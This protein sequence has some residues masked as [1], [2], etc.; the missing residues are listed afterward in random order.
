MMIFNFFFIPM[1]FNFHNEIILIMYIIEIYNI[2]KFESFHLN[3]ILINI[4]FQSLC[5]CNVQ[6]EV[7]DK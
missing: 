1:I 5:F 3:K 4:N 2:K 7:F 6:N